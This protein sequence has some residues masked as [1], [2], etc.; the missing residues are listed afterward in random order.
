MK[1]SCSV[2]VAFGELS[3]FFGSSRGVYVT[4]AGYA[5]GTTPN[6]TYKETCTG[7]TGHTE[8]VRVIFDPKQVPLETLLQIFWEQHDPTQGNRQGNDIG[9]Q[10]RSA[11][12]TTTDAQLTVARQS[13]EAFQQ[14]LTQAGKGTITTEIRPL[15]VFYYAEAYHQQYLDK[16]PG[17]ILRLERHRRHLRHRVKDIIMQHR[18]SR[19][20]RAPQWACVMTLLGLFA[21]SAKAEQSLPAMPQTAEDT[22]FASE[23]EA[24]IW[25]QDELKDLER[26]LRQL[27]FDLVNNQDARGAAPRLAELQEKNDPSPFFAS[28]YCRN[29]WTWL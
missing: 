6:P 4:A 29:R 12:F 9:S 27:R 7:L 22:P 18:S 15:D 8:V 16:N 19:G 14:A 1:R 25:R 28:L 24:V 17:G 23:R 21:M 5:G 20:R 10:Y 11:I 13:A 3:A 2:W 26:L